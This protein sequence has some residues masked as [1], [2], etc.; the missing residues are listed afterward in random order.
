MATK[1]KRKTLPKQFEA[2]LEAGE[3]EPLRRVFDAC[4]VDARGGYGKQTA[5]S[6][7]LCPDELARWLAAQGANVNAVDTWGRTALHNRVRSRRSRIDVLFEIG[8]DVHAST[9]SLETPLHTAAAAQNLESATALIA[10]GARVDARDREGLT[11][12]ELALHRCSNAALTDMA[13][14]ARRMLDAGAL[15]T[16]VTKT[17]VRELGERF[18]FHR[19]GFAKD[20]VAAASA[21]LDSLYSLFDVPPVPRRQ[22]YDGVSPIVVKPGTWQEQHEALWHQLVP[23]SGPANT[24]QGEVI[25]IAGRM[26]DE[27]D[28]NGGVNWD[29]AYRA[30]AH[31]WLAHVQSGTA[32]TPS[33]I[34]EASRIVGSLTRSARGDTNRLAEL[35]VAWVAQNPRPVP[36]AKPSYHR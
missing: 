21:G 9:P 22:M 10:H 19:D 25:R 2:L 17:C 18:E 20:S 23:S 14:L 30:M 4:E 28:R 29:E 3:L 1:R 33:Q 36:H 26:A 34:E 27:I 6:F 11:P 15:P 8:C 12:L 24:V 16:P 7:D 13:V 5:L 31:A 32:L 35:G